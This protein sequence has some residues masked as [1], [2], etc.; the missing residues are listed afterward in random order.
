VDLDI[1]ADTITDTTGI[2]TLDLRTSSAAVSVNLGLT[3]LQTI[4][5][6]VQ[7]TIPTVS[8]ENVYGGTGNDTL[9]GNNFSN[10]LLGGT[11]NDRLDGDEGADVLNGGIGNDTMIGGDGND[12]FIIDADVDTGIDT[13]TETAIGGIDTLYFGYSTAAININLGATATQSIAAGILLTLPI[14]TIENAS[15]GAGNDTI[16]GNNSDNNLS[17]NVGNDRLSSGE[18]HDTL[19]GGVGNDNLNGGNGN[20]T[21]IIDADLDIGTDTINETTIGGVDT[22][23]FRTSTVAVKVDLSATTTQTIRTGV[24]LTAP[25]I[26]LENAYGGVGNDTIAGN[27]LNNTILGSIGN[28]NLSGGAGHDWINGGEGHD[29]LI[30]GIGNDTLIGGVGDDY[31]IIDAD[32]DTGTKTISESVLS[33]IDILDFRSSTT[34]IKVNLGTT[35]AQS[36][37]TGIQLTTPVASIEYT[38]GGQGNDSITGNSLNNILVGGMGNDTLAGDIGNDFYFIDADVDFGTDTIIETTTGGVDTLDFRDSTIAVKVNLGATTTQSIAAGVQLT[39]PIISIEN[40]AGGTGNDTLTGNNLNNSLN[41]GTGNDHLNGGEGNDILTGGSGNDICTGGNGDDVYII[42]ADIHLGTDTINETTTGGIDTLDFQSSSTAI[43]LNLSATLTQAVAAGVNLTIP[44]T[45]LENAYGGTG[46][47]LIAGNSLNNT[48]TS[49]NGNDNLGGAIG[50]DFLDGGNGNDNLTGGV[51]NDTLNGGIGDDIYIIDADVDLGTDVINEITVGGSDTIDF[52][53]S[54]AAINVNLG[55]TTIQTVATGVRLTASVV[56]LENVYGG[57]GADN[58]SGN[59]LHNNLIGG[60][61]NDILFGGAGNDR[62]IYQTGAIFS[63]VAIG[64][65]TITDFTIGNDKLV[66]SQTTFAKLSGGLTF[67]NV[68]NDSL[69][70]TSTAVIVYSKATGKLFY[71]ENGIGLNLGTGAQ[72][73]QLAAGL[74]LSSGDFSLLS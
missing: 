62:F 36:I 68:V 10:S 28:D 55:T 60:V 37:A 67:A 41:S 49:G 42:D 22:I 7:L 33:G 71:N 53:S 40:I 38:Y 63:G 57:S 1:G 58:L 31:Y 27:N 39:V 74:N 34:G 51:G 6:G 3:T 4:A 12:F 65:D 32:T 19:A 56:S 26:S 5:A 18:G 23:D 47:D 17:G 69:V 61:G 52:R 44:L 35:T 9:I 25:V 30:G 46:N 14:A 11:G 13:I 48:L 21:Y 16:T 15:G 59:G 45:N 2:D 50:N 70:N 8:L 43:N 20:D 73:A 29:L 54:S 64:I 24:Q 66:L 72:F